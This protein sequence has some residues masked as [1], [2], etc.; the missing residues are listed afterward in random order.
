MHDE[1]KPGKDQPSPE[2]P[3]IGPDDLPTRTASGGPSDTHSEIPASIG[4]Y[5]I[6]HKLGEGGMGVVYEAEQESPRRRVAVKVVRGGQFVDEQRVRLF[7]REAETLACLKR[8]SEALE[9]IILLYESWGKP[10]KAEEW[11]EK[12]SASG[13]TQ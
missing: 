6:L 8:K 12:L 1:E 2:E 3:T 13:D 7:Q 5:K 10:E 11:R 4:R 9:R